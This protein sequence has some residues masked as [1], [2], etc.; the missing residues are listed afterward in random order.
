MSSVK[1]HDVVGKT[2]G[3]LFYIIAKT[4]FYPD[5]KKDTCIGRLLGER[6][7]LWVKGG[8]FTGV[9][10]PA[11]GFQHLVEGETCF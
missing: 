4:F 3:R 6:K 7:I 2:L 9:S 5:E 11:K 1:H 8:R 10:A